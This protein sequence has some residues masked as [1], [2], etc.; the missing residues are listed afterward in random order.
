MAADLSLDVIKYVPFFPSLRMWSN[1]FFLRI[2]VNQLFK[3]L[4]CKISVLNDKE[5][6]RL[7]LPDSASETK[8][9][10]LNAPVVFPKQRL[11]KRATGRR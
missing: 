4:G 11:P 9:A 2:R 1:F 7:G 10:V 5:R 3:S 6:K 8:R